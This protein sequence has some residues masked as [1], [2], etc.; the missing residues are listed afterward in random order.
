[1][2]LR[3]VTSIMPSL[4]AGNCKFLQVELSNSCLKLVKDEVSGG[5]AFGGTS[6]L[7]HSPECR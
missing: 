2:A 1:M 7:W 3:C 4:N 5:K 6:R